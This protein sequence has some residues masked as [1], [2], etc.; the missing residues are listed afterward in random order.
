MPSSTARTDRPRST[1]RLHSSEPIPVPTTQQ[2][3]TS[4]TDAYDP[5]RST[6]SRVTASAPAGWPTRA[7]SEV[8][9]ARATDGV[10]SSGR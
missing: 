8:A 4:P 10:V 1:S 5:V 9:S 3:L 2:A 6:T 7:S